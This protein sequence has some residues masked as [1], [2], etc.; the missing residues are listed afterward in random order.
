[1]SMINYVQSHHEV[2]AQWHKHSYYV[3][4]VLDANSGYVDIY[5]CHDSWGKPKKY[6][7]HS[8][9]ICEFADTSEDYKLLSPESV[10]GK[11]EDV[12]QN[13]LRLTPISLDSY[14]S[15]TRAE[16]AINV[17]SSGIAGSLF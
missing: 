9:N 1:M 14:Q 13:M 7:C 5:I 2:T 17:A 12:I 3:H 15:R 16:Q 6:V 10:R 4:L 11:I 8:E